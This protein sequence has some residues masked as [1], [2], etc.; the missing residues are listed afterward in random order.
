MPAGPISALLIPG[1]KSE[2]AGAYQP[3]YEG[4]VREIGDVCWLDAT[5]DKLFE[6]Y[7]IIGSAMNPVRWDPGRTIP[8][9]KLDGT[10]FTITNR[11]FG[12]R[13][14]LPRNYDDEQT[15]RLL[16][17]SRKLG[18][19]WV[20]LPERIFYQYIQSGTDAD[21]L[22]AVPNSA[23][24]NALY[25][26]TTRYG[27]ASGNVVT[28]TGSSTTQEIITDIYSGVRRY[29]EF[30]TTRDSQP[31]WDVQSTS[32]I[33]VYYGTSLTLLM[34]QVARQS[35]TSPCTGRST[36]ATSG[37]RG[38]RTAVSTCSSATC[39]TTSVR[40]RGRSERA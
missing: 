21:L 18:Q 15:G 30:Q 6:V 4:I 40:S 19:R 32:K 3:R 37:A 8:T 34:E 12:S 35:R 20:L 7:G 10:N 13:V 1:M 26:T 38:S 9:D 24:G 39:R 5:S 28:Q 27:S 25:L 16:E 11:D 22:P 17:V 14:M 23:D 2:L 31:F 33:S 36:G 29:R